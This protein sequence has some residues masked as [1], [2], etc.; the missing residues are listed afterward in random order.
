M[1]L[2]EIDRQWMHKAIFMTHIKKDLKYIYDFLD[3]NKN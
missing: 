3:K 2:R 1:K